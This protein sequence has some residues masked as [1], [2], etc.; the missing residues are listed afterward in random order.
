MVN[1]EQMMALCRDA[2][3]ELC[4]S[5]RGLRRWWWSTPAASYRRANEE[6]IENILADGGAEKGRAGSR[7][8]LVTG[9]MT[10]RY[11]E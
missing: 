2:G 9:C 5:A 4:R 1:C 6:A 7:K 3:M 8:I 10:Q 11:Q